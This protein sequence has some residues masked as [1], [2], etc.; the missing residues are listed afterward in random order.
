VVVRR[1]I[2]F[3]RDGV[4]AVPTLRD[5]RTYAPLSL[6]EFQI[7][8]RAKD[9]IQRAKDA[10]FLC[11]VVTNQPDVASGKT[12]RAIVNQMHEMLRTTLGF[13]DIEVSFDPSGSNTP[14]RKPNAG[15]LTDAAA[16]WGIDLTQSFMIGDTWKDIQAARAAGCR[17]VLVDHGYENEPMPPPSDYQASDVLD[18]VLWCVAQ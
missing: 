2:F 1:A 11:I 18:A 6:T 3:D 15:M 8:P 9:A 5:G 13:D 4:L 14:R 16:K 12:T 17:A 10:G 7:Y